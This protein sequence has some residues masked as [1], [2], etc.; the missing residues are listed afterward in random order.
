M[1]MKQEGLNENE[2]RAREAEIRT[3]AHES[4]LRS[5]KEFFILEK[6]AEEEKVEVKEEDLDDEIEALAAK[7]DES[8]RRVRARIEKENLG[9]ALASQ[10]LERKTLDRIFDYVKYN[11]VPLV[12]DEVAV[13]TLD[14]TATLAPS[15]PAAEESAAEPATGET[16]GEPSGAGQE[17][18]SA[19]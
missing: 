10:I 9:E 14:Q 16:G 1:Q 6:I 4:T 17:S 15:Q 2:I 3:N 12:E 7:S 19:D 18:P 13:E 8:A 11:E 5:L